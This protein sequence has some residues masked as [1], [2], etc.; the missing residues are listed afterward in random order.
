VDARTC[1]LDWKLRDVLGLNLETQH[2][3][4]AAISRIPIAGN[5]DGIFF[6]EHG[7]KDWL[8]RQ[9]RR[10]GTPP[11]FAYQRKFG[12]SNGPVEGHSIHIQGFLPHLFSRWCRT[13]N[14][15]P[16]FARFL[17]LDDFILKNAIAN[18]GP[19]VALNQHAI[20]PNQMKNDVEGYYQSRYGMEL[21]STTTRL[22]N[23]FSIA[24]LVAA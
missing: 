11:A 16:H 22:S 4:G 7:I 17:R 19:I 9:A 18:I 6:F 21:T 20:F 10:E 14:R 1:Y 12:T 3:A 23:I 2:I 13:M 15:P 5:L 8:V 24:A